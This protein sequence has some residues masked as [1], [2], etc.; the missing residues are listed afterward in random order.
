MYPTADRGILRE[1]LIGRKMRGGMNREDA[2]IRAKQ[3][4]SKQKGK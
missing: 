1:R 4:A 3:E 2:A